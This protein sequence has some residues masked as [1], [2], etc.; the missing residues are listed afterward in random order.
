M[1]SDKQ[2]REIFVRYGWK[3]PRN[4]N[5]FA[6]NSERTV[7]CVQVVGSGSQGSTKRKYD[8]E[9][10][11]EC[12]GDRNTEVE[13]MVFL[14]D[15]AGNDR[16]KPERRIHGYSTCD[17]QGVYG[18]LWIGGDVRR[19]CKSKGR[20]WISRNG[21]TKEAWNYVVRRKSYSRPAGGEC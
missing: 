7:Q 5:Q 9:N 6:V 1:F 21:G 13:T 3:S 15:A 19:S 17:A 16:N 11:N 14:S 2:K 10:C 8:D 4:Y 12:R 18:H 20:V